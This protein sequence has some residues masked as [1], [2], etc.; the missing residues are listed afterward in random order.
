[1]AKAGLIQFDVMRRQADMNAA[2]EARVQSFVNRLTPAMNEAI[3]RQ[4]QRNPQVPADVHLAATEN[5]S[6]MD[7]R[8]FDEMA[9][10]YHDM[11]ME[12]VWGERVTGDQLRFIMAMEEGTALA[13]P[14]MG[15]QVGHDPMSVYRGVL[16]AIGF[17][18]GESVL[19]GV[20]G[21]AVGLIGRGIRRMAGPS[22]SIAG[23]A[24]GIIGS[25][26]GEAFDRAVPDVIQGGVEQT[27]DAAGDASY[28]TLRGTSRNLMPALD[29][30]W[31]LA[32]GTARQ[33][34]AAGVSARRGDFGQA[35]SDLQPLSTPMN[36]NIQGLGAQTDWGQYVQ[37]RGEQVGGLINR[38]MGRDYELRND[39]GDGFFAADD[40][41]M[42]E[43]R[44]AAERA[45][46][47]LPNG[48]TYTIGRTVATGWGLEE[49]SV[50]YNLMSGLFDA[51][52]QIGTPGIESTFARGLGSA[53][54]ALQGAPGGLAPDAFGLVDG[55]TRGYD[56]EG[57]LSWIRSSDSNSVVN[58]I[59]DQRG[60]SGFSAIRR[61]TSNSIPPEVVARLA[62]SNDPESVR[63]VLEEVARSQ[64][65]MT[66]RNPMSRAMGDLTNELGNSAFFRTSGLRRL[67]GTIPDRGIWFDSD[68]QPVDF[69]Y[70]Y[71]RNIRASDADIDRWALAMA[72]ATDR[73]ARRNVAHQMLGDT[74]GRLVEDYGFSVDRGRQLTRIKDLE[75]ETTR[76]ALR[77]MLV[78][79][80][81]DTTR[82]IAGLEGEALPSIHLMAQ[83][84]QM[85]PM[86]DYRQLRRATGLMR[87]LWEAAEVPAEAGLISRIVGRPMSEIINGMLA[88]QFRWKQAKLLRA[89]Y[90]LRTWVTEEGGR[91]LVDGRTGFNH[92][93]GALVAWL[94]DDVRV[95]ASA[96]DTVLSPATGRTGAQ[97]AD[98]AGALMD[99]RQGG[100]LN[101]ART[102]ITRGRLER[103][104]N[105]EYSRDN[106]VAGWRQIIN[107]LGEDVIS[108][109]VA[110]KGS[111][112]TFDWLTNGYGREVWRQAQELDDVLADPNML[113]SYLDMID[114]EIAQ[115]SAGHPEILEAIANGG[116]DAGVG[117][118]LMPYARAGQAPESV[119]GRGIL[120]QDEV[121][122][123]DRWVN[124]VFDF[125]QTEPSNRFRRIP[126]FNDA[127]ESALAELAPLSNN[128]QSYLKALKRANVTEETYATAA[129][130][131]EGNGRLPWDRIDELARMA[132][133]KA[134]QDLLFDIS[135]SSQFFDQLQL[136]MPFGEAWREVVTTWARLL[137]RDPFTAQRFAG[138][139]GRA[140][141]SNDTGQTYFDLVGLDQES[142]SGFFYENEFGD[143][144]FYYPGSRQ[145]TQWMS[146]H[147]RIGPVP[148][149]FMRNGAPGV[150]SNLEGTARG[151]NI[152]GE[153]FPGFG[154]FGGVLAS[155]V[156]PE[157]PSWDWVRDMVLPF[158]TEDPLSFGTYL[159]AWLNTALRSDR[160]MTPEEIRL[161]GNTQISVMR[162]LYST[163]DYTDGR[164]GYLRLLEHSKSI[165]P[166]LFL[167]RATVQS[168]APS[169][170]A[171]A[172]QM[173]GPDGELW[174]QAVVIERY[175][176]LVEEDPEGALMRFLEEMGPQALLAIQGTTATSLA[177]GT[178]LEGASYDWVRANPQVAEEH[179]ELHG[180]FAPVGEG[181]EFSYE[182][183]LRSLERGERIVLSP[184][185]A[186]RMANNRF[187]TEL[188]REQR[189]LMGDP[190]SP[191]QTAWLDDYQG[192]LIERF[193]GYETGIDAIANRTPAYSLIDQGLVDR[194]LGDE[195][196]A[197]TPVGE[198]LALYWDFRSGVLEQ[199][200]AAGVRVGP[201]WRGW[202]SAN[203]GRPYRDALRNYGEYLVQQ[204]PQFARMW[205]GL[206]SSEFKRV[207]DEDG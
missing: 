109:R 129:R 18:A 163:G 75:E 139:T 160:Q 26:G 77:D 195:L 34:T 183:Y 40:S 173:I 20:G 115:I 73:G 17:Q 196:L 78:M 205:D 82:P 105:N 19:P 144:V 76:I 10:L 158:G 146:Q 95:G 23:Q 68:F 22:Q 167:A 67:R 170:P 184:D 25:I 70:D 178:P 128:P 165:T 3:Q 117:L 64:R 5:G 120:R 162:Y 59:A 69:V 97:V 44:R 57:A 161:Y 6:V 118:E 31:Q 65:F 96:A 187:A 45:M 199:A 191:E 157:D 179:A 11:G 106:F 14:A 186:M 119:V 152:A 190:P 201:N 148:I 137:S 121:G 99:L 30:P 156:L 197:Q 141:A 153:V 53:R 91:M 164:D 61:A 38:G 52:V 51:A 135:K 79:S 83:M 142:E 149:P 126:V 171:V 47:T 27:L 13:G 81:D 93:A 86:P 15:A 181:S 136:L 176:S 104:F 92:P 150:P 49:D 66:A 63:A 182:A 32:Q 124:S 54:R 1:M 123:M 132:G 140:L 192:W 43:R 145:F 100:I 177:G 24:A 36:L 159:P 56:M 169:S 134:T 28:A 188:Y 42:V 151:L 35:L 207:E 101:E 84:A 89:G 168:I 41:L 107:D 62:R 131:A 122:A 194:A 112:E 72:E 103:F 9:L 87:P 147:Q 71:G 114:R 200:E 143:M 175:R 174:R 110:S 155:T 198:S 58:Y 74:V 172:H 204:E 189:A 127:Y 16:D 7:D 4:Y 12:P 85:E 166:N 185:Q 46:G 108:Q 133:L 111:A 37:M 203:E 154:V 130:W 55:T 8:L 116:R 80:S 33:V 138:Q 180:F 125:M 193:P 29:L 39:F 90:P 206:L 60:A 102:G 94:T 50:G 48:Q 98:E 202:R 113:R 88:I 2:V 21:E